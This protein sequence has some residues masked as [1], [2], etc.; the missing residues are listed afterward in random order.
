MENCLNDRNKRIALMDNNEMMIVLWFSTMAILW[1]VILL[2]FLGIQGVWLICEK[3]CYRIWYWLTNE[4]A[5][6]YWT[7]FDTEWNN[8][9]WL[10]GNNQ[11]YSLEYFIHH[12]STPWS[13]LIFVFIFSNQRVYI[14]QK[15]AT[16]HLYANSIL[17][18]SPFLFFYT[19]GAL[20]Y[21]I[22]IKSITKTIAAFAC[23]Q[24]VMTMIK[25]Y[26]SDPTLR[27]LR[28]FYH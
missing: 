22:I 28:L 14:V 20:L 9:V 2:F 12:F 27:Q 11:L 13:I 16:N 7:K 8:I 26:A 24:K 19:W 3:E 25:D 18:C 5:V 4:L 17:I 1:S 23:L 10:I 15:K 21:D 6:P